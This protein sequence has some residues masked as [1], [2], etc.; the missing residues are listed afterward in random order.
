MLFVETLVAGAMRVNLLPGRI[1][2]CLGGG[3]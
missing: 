3:A 2:I 1:T